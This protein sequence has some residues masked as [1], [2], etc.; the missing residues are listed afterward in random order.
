MHGA[1]KSIDASAFFPQVAIMGGWAAGK[2]YCEQYEPTLMRPIRGWAEA[3][4]LITNK[5]G[6]TA[7]VLQKTLTSASR[8]GSWCP[9]CQSPRAI[10]C[11]SRSASCK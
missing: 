9:S 2:E 6:E 1:R 10:R 8:A 4:E 5:L 3:N 7:E 11:R